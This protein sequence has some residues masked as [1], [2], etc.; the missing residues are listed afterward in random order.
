MRVFAPVVVR[1]EE[2]KGVR[3]WEFGK[4]V[5]QELLGVMMDEDYGD[6][7]DV[8]KGRD[9]TV[10]V[11]SAKE[12]GK[13]YPTT[14][15]RVKPNQTALSDDAEQVESLLNTQKNIKE[16]FTKYSFEEM[17]ESLQKYLAVD[18]ENPAEKEEVQ[19]TKSAAKKNVDDKIDELFD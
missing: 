18:E 13:M 16:F 10:E 19:Y 2:D 5:Y 14:T 1:G 11:I 7:T 17:K 3:F 9:V 15:V 4:M 8:V 12:T 6:I